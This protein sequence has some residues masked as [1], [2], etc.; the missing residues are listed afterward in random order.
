MPS[1][2]MSNAHYL[3]IH[4]IPRLLDSMVLYLL[5]QRPSAPCIAL[6]AWLT[7]IHTQ[8]P[9]TV[10]LQPQRSH[11]P[12]LPASSPK[13][14]SMRRAPPD[15]SGSHFS[16]SS[17]FSRVMSTPRSSSHGP[18][19]TVRIEEGHNRYLDISTRSTRVER[20]DLEWYYSDDP[21]A[22]EGI[23]ECFLCKEEPE[24][25][26]VRMTY[27]IFDLPN[28]DWRILCP[29]CSPPD[30]TWVF[31]RCV[32]ESFL[33]PSDVLQHIFLFLPK[34]PELGLVCQQ[35]NEVSWTRLHLRD[36]VFFNLKVQTTYLFRLPMSSGSPLCILPLNFVLIGHMLLRMYT[37]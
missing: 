30:N 1:M 3:R 4:S 24:E 11:S 32:G 6:A 26:A 9:A 25:D 2:E 12:P 13:P 19:R 31:D 29:N 16:M 34:T 17:T 28:G 8:A 14:R 33:F 22:A 37:S 21:A 18:R 20:G 5:H 36:D 10:E 7:S 15:L 35:W 27:R 23:V